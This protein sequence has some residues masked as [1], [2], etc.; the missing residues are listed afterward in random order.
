MSNKIIYTPEEANKKLGNGE[1]LVVDVRDAEEY[2]KG[3][4]P[5]AVNIP[6]MF[7][8]LSMT[9]PEGLQEIQDVFVP[10][11]RKAGIRND[12]TVIVYEESLDT[13]Y[14]GSCR[15]YFQLS[16][17]GHKDVGVIG[18]GL[19]Q[20]RHDGLP[21]STEATATNPSDFKAS[22]QMDMLA[23]KD[24]VVAALSNP[25][26]KLLDNRDED[27]WLGY[28]SSPYGVDFAPRKGRIPG[29]CWVEWYR[30]MNP[31]QEIQH[32]RSPDEIRAICAQ[33]G[34]YPKDNIIIYCFK[35]ARASNT[36]IA[37]KMAGFKN[38]RNYYGSWNEWSRNA[39]LPIH[40]GVLAA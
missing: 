33:V 18:G 21:V 19:A 34:L 27:E 25:W 5:G 4:I 22:I 32:F 9:T 3:H 26:I 1:A 40:E 10:L 36:Y 39:E 16:L 2:A 37:L 30:F 11:F 15:G 14:G 28:S 29:A 13:R 23:T 12:Q 17:M 24:E 31:D 35:G 6:E 8:T 7:T 38:V 20:W